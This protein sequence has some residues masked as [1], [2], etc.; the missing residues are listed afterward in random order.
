VEA[1]G[2]I[3]GLLGA[4]SLCCYFGRLIHILTVIALGGTITVSRALQLAT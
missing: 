1:L 4:G 3:V 2:K